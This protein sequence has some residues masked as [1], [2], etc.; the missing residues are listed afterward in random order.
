M[1]GRN[2][3]TLLSR[4]AMPVRGKQSGFPSL[5]VLR[6][7]VQLPLAPLMNETRAIISIPCRKAKSASVRTLPARAKSSFNSS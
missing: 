3:V 7:R 4:D 2:E 1:L 5:E 6:G